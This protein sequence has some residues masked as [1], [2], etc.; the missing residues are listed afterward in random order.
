MEETAHAG[1]QRLLLS[2][3]WVSPVCQVLNKGQSGIHP[4]PFP[5]ANQ[6]SGLCLVPPL[7]GSLPGYTHTHTQH[8]QLEVRFLPPDPST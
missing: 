1:T 5:N 7:P 8:P 2:M 6:T 4:L 3:A